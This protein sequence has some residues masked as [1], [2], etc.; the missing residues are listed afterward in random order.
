MHSIIFYS[1]KIFTRI[2][3]KNIIHI[4]EKI[5]FSL[6]YYPNRR[7]IININIK[8]NIFMGHDL[9]SKKFPSYFMIFED[10][11]LYKFYIFVIR[12]KNSTLLGFEPR[13]SRTGIWCSSMKPQGLNIF[14]LLFRYMI[15]INIK[16]LLNKIT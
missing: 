7:L 15:N 11:L 5:Q 4:R 13:I 12:E 16:L 14:L 8:I 2:I 6:V 3:F 1:W 10:I 9:P